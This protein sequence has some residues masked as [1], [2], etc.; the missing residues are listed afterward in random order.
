MFQ[1]L[2]YLLIVLGGPLLGS[3]E[4]ARAAPRY[5]TQIRSALSFITHY[6][7]TGAEGYEPGQWR[8]RVTSYVPSAVGVGKFA[9]PF[10][11]PSI[12]VTASIA[13]A[14]AEIY[15]LDS[16]YQEIPP[17]LRRAGQGLDIYRWG[18]LFNFYPPK[19]FRGV[20]VRGPRYMY[21]APQWQGFAN[22]PPDADT[23]SVTY[24]F[25][26]HL[27]SIQR[28]LSP[29]ELQSPLPPQV[30]SALST[31]RDM[32][33][34]PHIYN[35]AQG[36]INTGAFL[37]WFYDENNPDMPR[38]I[39]AAPHRGTRIPFNI[40]DVDCVVNANVL[41]LL[42]YSG[43][44]SGP[45][46]RASCEHLNTVVRKKQFYFCGM[47]YPSFYAF[48]YTIATG[49]KAG[50]SCL[51]QSRERVL[52]FIISRQKSDGSWQNSFL[53]RPDFIQSTAWALN[54]LM[55]L[56]DP[57]NSLHKERIRRGVNYLISQAQ[58]DSQGRLYWP[59]EV[60]FAATFV[61]RYPVVWR[62]TVYTTALATKALVMVDHYWN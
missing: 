53:A 61:A 15:Q 39:F 11:D 14:L 44:T 60:F 26:H 57:K 17:A 9:Q 35:A 37:T 43:A 19:V 59:G 13:N 22:I 18:S 21:L 33:R 54:T 16:R 42:T 4:T 55:L 23:T 47:Y 6:Q 45:G 30:I 2:A 34:K 38:N 62:S 49:L 12:F 27:Q 48:P 3:I 31:A 1:R 8:A 56:G 7:T 24:T 28:N 51:E 5:E 52:N 41:K 25:L 20:K 50:A 40:N 46:Y 29:S 32:N 36:H 10:E 58:K